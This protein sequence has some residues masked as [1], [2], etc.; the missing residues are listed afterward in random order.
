[1]GTA[2]ARSAGRASGVYC[3]HPQAIPGTHL[4]GED[5]WARNDPFVENS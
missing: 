2:D 1:M 3:R 5:S 4:P